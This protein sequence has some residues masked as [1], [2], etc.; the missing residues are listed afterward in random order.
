MN[1]L[2]IHQAFA[3]PND[4]SGTRHFE[5]GKYCVNKGHTFNVVT[6][7]ISYLT[8][9]PSTPQKG[10]VVEEYYDG[11]R[12][13]R[14]YTLPF[15]HKNYVFRVISFISFMFTSIIASLKVKKVD[16]VMGTSP[17]I[18]QTVS[19]WFLSLLHHKPFLLEIRDLWPEFAVDIGVLKSPILIYLSRW[20]ERFLYNRSTH[21]IINSPAYRDYLLKRGIKEEKISLIPNGV[22]TLLFDPNVKGEKLREKYGLNDKFVVTYAGAL[23]LANDIY[24]LLDAAN[25]LRSESDIHF[26]IAGDGKERSKLENYARTLN[27]SNVIFPGAIPKSEMYN[28][29]GMS[30][31]CIAI[32]KNIPMFKMTYPN[33]VF[34][35]MAA[36]RPI[37]L[38]IDGVIKKVV[39][40]GKCGIFVEPGNDEGIADAIMKLYENNEMATFMGLSGRVFVEKYFNRKDHA[41]IFI[42][43]LTQI[44]NT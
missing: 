40:D 6:S 33:K 10:I 42:E 34:D 15:V 29:L 37:V 1:I 7:K 21:I 43:V 2:L 11:V 20:L 22:D 26:F 13:L 30:D 12:I 44:I 9:K 27:L 35:Y 17:P 18:F 16:L 31:A 5:F 8:G 38:A 24:T 36:G 4:P 28:I 3:S 32:L 25:H 39:E 41:E 14:A 19:A 23:G